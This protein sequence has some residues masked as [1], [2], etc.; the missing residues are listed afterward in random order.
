[1]KIR[2]ALALILAA[3]P[4]A[5]SESGTPMNGAEFDAYTHGKT[6]SF[7]Q[8]GVRYGAE[9]YLSNQSVVWA[10]DGDQCIQGHWYEPE[11]GLICFEY[12]GTEIG[13]QCWRFYQNING[14][15][16]VFNSTD[17]VTELYEIQK[18]TDELFCPGPEIGV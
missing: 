12:D 13:E 15:R 4:A 17:A 14:L 1:M 9:Q 5:R 6:L 7:F 16:A 8:D 2:L 11:T 3:S 10:F 18:S